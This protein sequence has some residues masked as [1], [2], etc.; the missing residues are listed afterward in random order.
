[1][2][3][4][5]LR[6][7]W[8]VICSLPERFA[9]SSTSFAPPSLNRFVRFW[10]DR[11]ANPTFF[12]ISF[13]D[14][15]DLKSDTMFASLSFVVLRILHISYREELL[16]INCVEEIAFASTLKKQQTWSSKVIPQGGYRA[17]RCNNTTRKMMS[18]Q[19][20]L[21]GDTAHRLCQLI[22]QCN[23]PCHR[24]TYE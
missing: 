2:S 4:H 10:T 11:S 24:P 8:V 5:L 21:E 17:G 20:H 15:P 13:T 3:L 23:G 16:R 19:A 12:E 6:V 9:C 7:H 18:P 1:M 14:C 22:A